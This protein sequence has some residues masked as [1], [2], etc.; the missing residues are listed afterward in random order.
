MEKIHVADVMTREPV[1]AYPD[2][3]LLKC[4][5]RMVKKHVGSLV[6]VNQDNKV[7]GFLS[8]K[9]VLWA[10]VKKSKKDLKNIKA[11][12]VAAKKVVTIKPNADIREAVKKMEKKKFDRLPVVLKGK[13]LVGIITVKDVLSFQPEIY[14]ELEEYAKIRDEQ[15]KLKRI[16]DSSYDE[17]ISDGICEECGETDILYKV[18]GRIVCESC[19]SDL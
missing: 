16:K 3:D 5:K 15:E 11:K 2:D 13:K 19:M 10:I 14:P 8:Q 4:S 12:Q 1:T 6:L 17:V 18:D 9:D 7:V